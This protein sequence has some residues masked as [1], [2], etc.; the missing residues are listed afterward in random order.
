MAT[1]SPAKR[2]GGKAY[3][4]KQIRKLMP[5]HTRYIEPY[6][7]SGAV[8]FSGDGENVAE[9]ANDI[10]FA[11]TNF[12]NTLKSPEWFAEFSRLIAMT[13]FSEWEFNA[14]KI[15][16]NGE[17]HVAGPLTAASFFVRNR[18]S[19]QALEKDFATP[20]RR[21]RRGMNEQ[22]SAWLS[23]VD[24]LPEFHHRLR[25]VEIRCGDAVDFIREL[26]S[27][28]TFA[29]I[30]PPYV[31]ETRTATKCYE[32]EMTEADHCRLLVA[33]ERMSGK[34]ILSG[35][36]CAMYQDVADRCGWHHIDIEIDN[37]SSGSKVKEKKIERLWMNHEPG[38]L[39]S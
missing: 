6:F 1:S 31:H 30:D 38:T 2:H 16:Q 13:P 23:A 12:W 37:K 32:H 17:K 19:R 21:L 15:L 28:E 34:F 5:P 3:L 36:L 14:S 25:R 20:T 22:V 4:A 29:Y 11:L 35:Y 10:D 27:E 26:D 8:L 7:G 39:A 18:Q 24:G 9:F 33:L